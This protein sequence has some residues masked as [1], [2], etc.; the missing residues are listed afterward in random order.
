MKKQPFCSMLLAGVSLTD[1]GLEIPSPFCQLEIS[2]AEIDSY[3]S[4]TLTVT[5]AGDSQRQMNASAFE[6]LLYSGAQA[7]SGYQNSS[8]IPVSFMFGW[9]D[10]NGNVESHL[11]YQGW[12][13]NFQNSS[14]G[15]F[16]VYTVTGY[17]QLGVQM[18]V[19]LINVPALCG[20]VQPSAVVEGLA[21]AVHADD[22]YNLDIDHCDAPTLVNHNAMTTSF[23]DYVR[24]NYTGE[25]DY[26]S[27]PGLL[28]LSTSYNFSREAAGLR[29][30]K[31]LS[32][33]INNATVTPISEFLKSALTDYTPQ[34]STFSFWVE[35]PTMTHM[36][37][38]HYKSNSG[39][40][41]SHYMDTLEYGTSN[42]N[43]LSLTGSYNGV[44]YNIS[45]MNLSYVGFTVD[46]SGNSIANSGQV[47]NSWSSS[48]AD[49]FQT[50]NIINDVNAMA[51]QF[52]GDF[53][54]TIAGSTKQYKLAQPVSL[55]VMLGNTVSPMSGIY[56]I[57][58]VSHSINNSFTT[59]LKLQR[60][61][62][63]SANQVATQQGLL[64]SN[65]SSF[66]SSSYVKT[67]NVVSA[68]KVDF[69]DIYP[70]FRDMCYL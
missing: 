20:I 51:T 17:A 68:N 55:L 9:L 63:S 15:Q 57:M 41:T 53:T 10:E 38:I 56:N 5:V 46:G 18:S 44:S 40:F 12:T 39:L 4:W 16:L 14:S 27:F 61:V 7:A 49:V 64:V 36:G 37:T 59:S 21:K 22:Y 26:Q 33:A 1:F 32:T 42:T 69:G 31:K 25:D 3:T 30:V 66:G 23:T 52:S 65:E 13:L 50:A 6:A 67:S 47:V 48:L 35:E 11:S 43:I 60:L 58:S 28:K 29:K 24:G 62:M 34:A 45:D 2:E 70:T 19:P 54:V 8:G